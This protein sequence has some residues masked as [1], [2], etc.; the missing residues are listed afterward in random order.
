MKIYSGKSADSV[1]ETGLA[2]NV[3]LQLAEKLFYQG[4]TLYID[5]FYTSYELAISCLNRKTHV[6]GT[7]RNNKKFLPKDILHCKLRKGEM[8]SK[9]DDNGIVV[10]KWRGTRDV[11]ILST[12]HAPI[13]VSSTKK[14]RSIR[15]VSPSQQTSATLKP[16]AVV[17]Y[18]AGKSGIDYSDQMVSYATT[19]RKGIK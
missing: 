5:N 12:K 15:A 17:E 10:L 13:M 11:R 18:N 7:L 8:I 16:L 3:C 6:V 1:R 9:E 2:H 19:I 14:N 4:R